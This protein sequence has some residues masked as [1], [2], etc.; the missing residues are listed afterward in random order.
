MD[1]EYTLEAG[2]MELAAVL[3]VREKK[4]CRE[5]YLLNSSFY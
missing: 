1:S 2:V 4:K 5:I 3:S